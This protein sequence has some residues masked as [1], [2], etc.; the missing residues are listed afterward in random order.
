MIP[1]YEIWL[2]HLTSIYY[3]K[4]KDCFLYP[5]EMLLVI[6]VLYSMGLSESLFSDGFQMISYLLI[7]FSILIGTFTEHLLPKYKNL[8]LLFIFETMI[9]LCF[10]HIYYVNPA[11]PKIY[12]IVTTLISEFFIYFINI[13]RLLIL[14]LQ[15]KNLICSIYIDMILHDDYSF[16]PISIFLVVL[17]VIINIRLTISRDDILRILY[18]NHMQILLANE[19]LSTI[20]NSMPVGIIVLSLDLKIILYNNTFKQKFGVNSKL[21]VQNLLPTL[22]YSSGRRVY[23]DDD[24]E[25]YLI[26]D[27]HSYMKNLDNPP[28]T[29]GIVERNQYYYEWR[30]NMTLWENFHAIILTARNVTSLIHLEKSRAEAGCRNAMLR[31]VSHELRT[32]TAII[33]SSAEQIT[34]DTESRLS[35]FAKDSLNIINVC[36]KVLLN[37]IH[38][39]IDFSQIVSGKFSIVKMK[40]SIQDLLNECIFLIYTQCRKKNIQFEFILDPHLP[41][42]AVNDANRIRQVVLNLLTN[43]LK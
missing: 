25:Q 38:D 31:S 27:I 12:V 42:F 19:K 26:N 43:A 41:T 6:N 14:L 28:T 36:A 16:E 20:I 13:H 1:S 32:P 34:E 35:D 24:T 5:C 7:N 23:S 29:F 22:K 30:A 9:N 8:A 40:F 33:S 10:A 17:V 21:Q 15:M 18:T 3:Q 2:E 4:V 39:L 37:I 11:H